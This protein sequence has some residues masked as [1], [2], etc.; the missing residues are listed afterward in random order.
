MLLFRELLLTKF[1]FFLY[2]AFVVAERPS[3]LYTSDRRAI[4]ILSVFNNSQGL[5]QFYDSKKGYLLR[6]ILAFF[7]E[8]R[9]GC[10]TNFFFYGDY[11][12]KIIRLCDEIRYAMSCMYMNDGRMRELFRAHNFYNDLHF[13]N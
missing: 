11:N 4:L 10:S 5:V 8:M 1:F 13:Q 12:K 9:D 3:C 7:N 6:F 2:D